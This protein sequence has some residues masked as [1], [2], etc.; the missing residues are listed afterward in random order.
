[1]VRARIHTSELSFLSNSGDIHPT[2]VDGTQRAPAH[3]TLR[4]AEP[5]DSQFLYQ[6]YAS[7]R[8]DEMALVD[9][10]AEQ[11]EVF[12]RMQFN[13][14]TQHYLANYPKAEYRIIQGD[15]FL[16]GRIIV[17]RSD[18]AIL[19]L[20]IALLPQYRHAGIGTSLLKDLLAEAARL[21]MPVFLHVEAFNPA[22]RLYER[23]GFVKTG[24]QGLYFEMTW[25]PQGTT[26]QI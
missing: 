15:Q 13:A 24:E 16:L 8:S 14:Q 18:Q 4:N 23:L 1:M 21:H 12:T 7:T 9:W 22:L 19:L 3:I 6:V 11:K 20:D 17:N 5:E 26:S 2:T 10:T 25:T